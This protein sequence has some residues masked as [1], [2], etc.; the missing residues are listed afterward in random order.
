MREDLSTEERL[1]SLSEEFIG[2][3]DYILRKLEE[4]MNIIC[5]HKIVESKQNHY[6][7]YINKLK[8][9][10]SKGYI[11]I[12]DFSKDEIEKAKKEC[13]EIEKKYGIDKISKHIYGSIS[14]KEF[15]K[16]KGREQYS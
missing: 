15:E 12:D 14:P 2:D 16:L 13:K 6:K 1:K 4:G 5:L 3:L 9:S 11:T 7:K 10:K 8:M